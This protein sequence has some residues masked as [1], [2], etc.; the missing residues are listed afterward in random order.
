[1]VYMDDI[2][3]FSATASEHIQLIDEVLQKLRGAGLKINPAKTTLVAH[4]VRYLGHVVSAAGVRPNPAKIQAVADLKAPQSAKEV[5]MFLGLAGY[6]RRFIPAFASLAAPLNALTKGGVKFE[7]TQ[8]HQVAFDTLKEKLCQAPI[9]EY[10]RRGRQN[11]IDCDASDEAAGA[12]LM[13]QTPEGKEVVIQYASYT[14]S[15]VEKRWPAMEKEAYAVVWAVTTF[16]AYV[17]GSTVIIR[18]DNTSS[19]TLK[20]AKHAKLQRWAMTLAEYD[21]ELRYRPGKQQSHVDALSRLPT[22]TERLPAPEAADLHRAASAFFAAPGTGAHPSL[23]VLDWKRARQQDTELVALKTYLEKPDAAGASPPAWFRTLPRQQQ[24]RFT[25]DGD[26]VIFR[27]F[28]PKDRARWVVPQGLRQALVACHHRGI[29]GAHMG[30]SKTN[31]MLSLRFYWPCMIDSVKQCI[32][33]CERC[34]RAKAAPRIPRIARML[35]REAL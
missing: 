18:T 35:N 27:G 24:A 5:K 9:L 4:E 14:F 13:Q 2:V 11:I 23:P 1:M 30:V 31:A 12:V 6:Y 25:V 34:L 8:Q 22:K 3:V 28:P 20:K 29:C 19:A 10:P 15:D 32:K 7:W 21:Y 17:L 33:T 16:R 26:D